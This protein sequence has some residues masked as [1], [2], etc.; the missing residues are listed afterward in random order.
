MVVEVLVAETDAEDALLEQ[1]EERVLDE[2]GVAMIGEAGGELI[3]KAK[4]GI[5]FAK[6]QSAGIGGDASTIE[7]GENF[8]VA[9]LLEG[10]RGRNSLCHTATAPCRKRKCLQ[11]QTHTPDR[12]L[13][14]F[15]SV[16]NPG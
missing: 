5:D 6:E 14:F 11:L 1:M 4:V 12:A 7:S 13:R 9:E 8:A 15:N 3:E 16:R 10:K 2:F